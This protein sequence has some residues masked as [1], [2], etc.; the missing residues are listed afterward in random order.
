VKFVRQRRVFWRTASHS[1]GIAAVGFLVAG[2]ATSTGILITLA[3]CCGITT[4]TFRRRA[5]RVYDYE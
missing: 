1:M 4:L 3:L 2:A 5:N